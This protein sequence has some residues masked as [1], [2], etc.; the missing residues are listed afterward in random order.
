[1]QALGTDNEM[2]FSPRSFVGNTSASPASG[3]SFHLSIQRECE[4]RAA[5]RTSN[6][7][8]A[9]ESVRRFRLAGRSPTVSVRGRPSSPVA[10]SPRAR[11]RRARQPRHGLR[12]GQKRVHRPAT[13]TNVAPRSNP[14]TFVPAPTRFQR[15]VL[16]S[17][18]VR[19]FTPPFVRRVSASAAGAPSGRGVLSGRAHPCR[20]PRPG[21]RPAASNDG[22][23]NVATGAKS[24][25][26]SAK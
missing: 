18:P 2:G 13:W 12:D 22:R 6:G 11:S 24:S 9:P 3:F 1:M 4:Y 21:S 26:E 15:T 16:V 5:V 19:G 20:G 10:F 17:S 25:G 14:G 8:S 23:T 7:P